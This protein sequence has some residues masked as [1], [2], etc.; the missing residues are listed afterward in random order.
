[1]N[2]LLHIC[3]A[4]C[5]IYPIEQIRGEG[6]LVAGFFYNPN[7]HPYNEYN[8]RKLALEEYCRNHAFNVIYAE[9]DIEKY[10]Q[11]VAYNEDPRN[12]C[13]ICWWIRLEKAAEFAMRNGFD[14]FSTTLLGSPYQDHKI[15]KSLSEDISDKTK[16]KFYYRDFRIG[17]RDAHNRAKEEGLYCQ[18]YCGC[19]FSEK[20]RYI[21]VAVGQKA[22]KGPTAAKRHERQITGAR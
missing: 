14:A 4:P 6:H 11:E 22:E 8:N 17:F 13:P 12:R 10:F 7:I 1:M 20:E 5:A 19:L 21:K 3:C 15:I 16:V 9:Y 18:K 2:I